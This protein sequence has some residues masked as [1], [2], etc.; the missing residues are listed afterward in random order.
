MHN[1]V[2][3]TGEFRVFL[4]ANTLASKVIFLIVA[5]FCIW[6]GNMQIIIDDLTGVDIQ[7]LVAFH[8]SEALGNSPPGQSFA[9]NL[10]G[11]RVPDMTFW[12]AWDGDV[13]MGCIALKQLSQRHGEIK[14]MRT[15]SDHLRK[16][17]AQALLV[18]LIGAARDRG[19]AR[20]SLETGAGPA[21]EAAIA[22]YER[23]GFVKGE[24][25]ADYENG[26]FNQCFHLDL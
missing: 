17:V 16:G 24:A 9:L 13:L 22:L 7:N 4:Q 5:N 1:F 3:V 23:N 10:A 14:S 21:Y 8:V 19:Y 6:R 11:L 20:V 26:E 18:H 12:S 25:F 15:H 2:A